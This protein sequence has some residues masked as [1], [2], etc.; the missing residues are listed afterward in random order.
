MAAGYSFPGTRRL[1]G[2]C[3]RG[4]E[5]S[6]SLRKPA[7]QGSELSGDVRMSAEP[8]ILCFA[9]PPLVLLS[10]SG[11][12]RLRT[13]RGA[14]DHPAHSYLSQPAGTSLNRKTAASGLMM[15]PLRTLFNNGTCQ[16]FV[17]V[18]HNLRVLQCCLR[19]QSVH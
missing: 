2:S 10:R 4:L 14:S 1:V 7:L 13:R 9:P 18:L 8:R 17:Q 3:R 19:R 12:L 5:C 16:A 6:H 11:V 15:E